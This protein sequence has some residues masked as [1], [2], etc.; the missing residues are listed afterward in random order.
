MIDSSMTM[1]L[2]VALL[3]A[4]TTV[5]GIG[6]PPRSIDTYVDKLNQVP[7]D[8]SLHD[9]HQLLGTAPHVAGSEGDWMVIERIAEYFDQLGFEVELHEIYPLLSSPVHASLEIVSGSAQPSGSSGR[10][11][12]VMQ[13]GLKEDDLLDDPSTS[14]PGLSWGWNAFSGSG[15]VTANIVYANYGRKE[16]FKRLAE[17]GI[18]LEGK[19]VLARYGGNYRGYKARFAQEAGAAGLLMYTDPADSGFVR[20]E[21]YPDG[22]WANQTCIQ[23]GSVLTLPYKGDPLTPGYEASIDARRLRPEDVDMPRIPVQPIGYAAAGEIISRMRGE[24]VGQDSG[25]QGGLPMPYRIEGGS[26]L[27]LRMVVQQERR[28]TRTANV[29]GTLAGTDPDAGEIIVGC[30]HDAW[31]FGAGDPLAGMICL[32]ECAR[33]FAEVAASGTR[34]LR[35]IR[36]AA[37]GAEEFGIIGSTEWCERNR[38]RLSDSG[39]CYVNLDMAAMGTRFR[40]SSAPPWKAAIAEAASRCEH[41]AHEPGTTVL[42]TWQQDRPS[43]PVGNLGGGSDHV[44]FYCHVGVPS[45]SLGGS[46]AAGSSYHSNYD[47]LAWYRKIVGDDYLA[48]LMVTRVANALI[49]DMATSPLLPLNLVDHLEAATAFLTQVGSR[50]VEV[51]LPLDLDAALERLDRMKLHAITIHDT[52]DAV[53]MESLDARTR[54]SIN[55]RLMSL[56]RSWMDRDGLEGRGWYRNLFAASK[57]DS[58][59]QSVMIPVLAEPVEDNDPVALEAAMRRLDA[60]LARLENSLDRIMASIPGSQDQ[61]EALPPSVQ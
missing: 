28:I 23:R 59:Y 29:I 14:H 35:T 48:A 17:L 56:D 3:A 1:K 40:S 7:T 47:T 25:W 42:Q 21:V 4:T 45:C 27:E 32:L 6:T 50:A 11:R 16:D 55:S 15:D 30:H 31:G 2:L 41:P 61:Q 39:I 51:G 20:G 58:G 60:V 12:G 52:L 34:P 46:G 38:Q 13:L 36:F 53:D 26:D 43:P 44:G 5:A 57:R 54:N 18:D 37:W 10:R 9:L 49:A 19:I 33:S 8:A 22:G 24:P